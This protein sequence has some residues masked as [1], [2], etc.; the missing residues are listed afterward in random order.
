MKKMVF[1]LVTACLLT[2][3]AHGQTE[4]SFVEGQHYQVLP[5]PVRVADRDRLEVVEV[6]SYGCIHCFNFQPAM[7]AWLEDADDDV[8][9]VRLPAV[10]DQSWAYLAK[11]FYSAEV[12]GV[13]EEVHGAVF[14]AVH[15]RNA[16]VLQSEQL[17]QIFEER[18]GIGEAEFLRVFNSVGV[19]TRVRQAD[20]Q[21]R[22]FRIQGTPTMVVQGKYRIDGQMAGSNAAMLDVVDFLLA[23]ERA[24]A[25]DRP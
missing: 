15:V 13:T 6:F 22:M 25:N 16:N 14:E 5:V 10:F 19:D 20:A 2:F 1:A 8:N 24:A 3:N 23:K 9:F 21:A 11:A 12:L 4:R 7:E 18:A 17:A